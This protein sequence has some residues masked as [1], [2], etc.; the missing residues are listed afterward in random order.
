M[1]LCASLGSS[2]DVPREASK[3]KIDKTTP[4]AGHLDCSRGKRHSH[5]FFELTKNQN[6]MDGIFENTKMMMEHVER[7][8]SMLPNVVGVFSYKENG[9]SIV[10]EVVQNYL[11]NVCFLNRDGKRRYAVI[12]F[13]EERGE[14]WYGV[15]SSDVPHEPTKGVDP[16]VETYCG[17]LGNIETLKKI[18]K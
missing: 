4:P 15:S 17:I 7:I 10:G 13:I 14:I 2:P 8:R 1:D 3:T 9:S 5:I 11:R 12:S 18:D 6:K 16:V